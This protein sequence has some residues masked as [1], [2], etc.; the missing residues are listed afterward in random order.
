[1]VSRRDDVNE[2]HTAPP[3]YLGVQGMAKPAA[4]PFAAVKERVS[5]ASFD[6]ERLTG[7]K[8]LAATGLAPLSCAQASEV[9]RAFAFS[10]GKIAAL[11]AVVG[12][13][14]DLASGQAAIMAG[15]SFSSDKD[16][17]AAIIAAALARPHPHAAAA[18]GG[19][20]GMPAAPP[21]GMGGGP[22]MGMPM[23]APVPM[24]GM[25]MGVPM[26]GVPMGMPM[27]MGA[28]VPGAPYGAYPAGGVPYGAYPGG[29][30]PMGM[31]MGIPG[32]SVSMGVT[33]GGAPTM[34]VSM[35]GMSFAVT[36]PPDA[37]AAGA[38]PPYGAYPGY[39]GGPY[40][41]AGPGMPGF[42]MSFGPSA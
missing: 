6:D 8:A 15:L 24:G 30:M 26:G 34:G 36:A 2:A 23:G 22:P 33:A 25:P 18:G 39:P 31:T 20:G 37:A 42:S 32:M 9:M 13:V 35:P 27:P 40:P 7:L 17:A 1:M 19:A 28:P 41:P 38:P 12:F 21:M 10:D 14:H 4:V 5:K 16:R 29:G 3:Q 11:E